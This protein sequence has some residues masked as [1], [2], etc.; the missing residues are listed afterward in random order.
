ME[1]QVLSL[2]LRG[3]ASARWFLH[4]LSEVDFRINASLFHCYA[5]VA[6]GK[7]YMYCLYLF[8]GLGLLGISACCCI[9]YL[10]LL[11]RL[12]RVH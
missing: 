12:E 6:P 8:L 9:L 5:S 3:P 2:D 10:S 4:G 7:L 11:S 1:E